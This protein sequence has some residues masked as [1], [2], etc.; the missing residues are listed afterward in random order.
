MLNWDVATFIDGGGIR[1]TSRRDPEVVRGS[2]E[3][4]RTKTRVDFANMNQL[5]FDIIGV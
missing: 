5:R 4:K 2:E 1:S 3:I